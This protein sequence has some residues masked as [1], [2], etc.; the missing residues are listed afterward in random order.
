MP[1][2]NDLNEYKLYFLIFENGVIEKKI[3]IP[4][5]QNS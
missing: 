5:K 3:L 4:K 2:H 1:V